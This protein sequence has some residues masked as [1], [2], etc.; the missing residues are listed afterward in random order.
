[1]RIRGRTIYPAIACWALLLV[2]GATACAGGGTGGGTPPSAPAK[3]ET[4]TETQAPPPGAPSPKAEVKTE[5][6]AAP[7]ASPAVASPAS[8]SASP[9]AKAALQ[10]GVTAEEKAAALREGQVTYYTA[11]ATGTAQRI[12][13][14]A[15]KALG[16]KVN[17]VR[18]SSSLAYNRAVQEFDQG[19]NQT[20]VIDTSVIDHF[21]D[22]KKRGMLQPHTPASIDLYRSPGYYDSEHYWHASQIGLAVLN[23]NKDLVKG[24]MIPKTWKE[25][26]DPK[27]KDKLFQGHIK[28][29]GT[30]AIIDFFLVKMYGWEYFEALRRNNILTQPSADGT[31]LLANGERLIA[32]ADHQVTAPAQQQGL[33]IETVFPEDGVFAQ[34]GPVALLAK[35]PH[36][37][38]GKLLIDWITSPAGQQIYVQGG[39]LSPIDSPE[40]KYPEPWGDLGKVK[41][42]MV[43]DP[44]EV[45]DWLPDAREKFSDLFGG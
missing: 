44:K 20:D 42:I 5:T 8:K 38:A 18:L 29:S 36:P 30:S 27:Y 33:P 2:A 26:A 32:L 14:A 22:M 31:N 10:G 35:A 11:R 28:A 23:Y 15:T 12:G 9:A 45:G 34:V 6:Q 1:M 25:L 16:I 4:K 7:A 3:T 37:N 24:D 19:V 43:P 17:I 41:N 39:T 21:V 40:I 13:E